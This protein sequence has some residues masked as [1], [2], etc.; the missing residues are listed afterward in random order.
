MSGTAVS[1]VG[2]LLPRELLDRVANND[3]KLPGLGATDFDLAPADLAN[4]RAMP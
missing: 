4:G 3:P 1:T 2:A